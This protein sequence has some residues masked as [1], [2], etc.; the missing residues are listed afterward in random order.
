MDTKTITKLYKLLALVESTNRY[1]ARLAARKARDLL[2]AYLSGCTKT[3]KVEL[4]TQ[5]V[6]SKPVLTCIDRTT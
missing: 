1:E 3:N 2:T 5:S 4:P 6:D